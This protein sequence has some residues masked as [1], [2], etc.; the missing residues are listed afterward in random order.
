MA[1]SATSSLP[2][3]CPS[4][5]LQSFFCEFRL[6]WQSKLVSLQEVCDTGL[7]GGS[8]G[9]A[10]ALN[11][12]TKERQSTFVAGPPLEMMNNCFHKNR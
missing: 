4:E 10:C 8:C 9:V 2:Q 3:L 12:S 11:R 7:R 1:R 5:D 6:S